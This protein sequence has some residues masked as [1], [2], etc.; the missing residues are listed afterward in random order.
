[1]KVLLSYVGLGRACNKVKEDLASILG[2]LGYEVDLCKIWPTEEYGYVGWLLRSLIPNYRV[3]IGPTIGDVSNYDSLFLISPKWAYSCPPFFTYLEQLVGL[4]GRSARLAVVY[5]SSGTSRYIK[6]IENKLRRKGVVNIASIS[7]N[8][9]EVFDGSYLQE[10][11]RLAS[12]SSI[13]DG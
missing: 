9:T 10:L 8:K 7:V 4:G 11:R 1:M 12:S 13:R 3:K 6:R 2:A 5:T